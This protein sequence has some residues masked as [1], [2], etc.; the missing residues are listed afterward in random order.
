LFGKLLLAHH[1]HLWHHKVTHL[2]PYTTCLFLCAHLS[3]ELLFFTFFYGDIWNK[4]ISSCLR[5]R[6]Q[7]FFFIFPDCSNLVWKASFSTS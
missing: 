7:C 4:N 6:L 5:S 1:S 2:A 3:S